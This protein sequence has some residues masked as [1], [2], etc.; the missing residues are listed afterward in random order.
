MKKKQWKIHS[1]EG[2]NEQHSTGWCE[3]ELT[4]LL[5]PA[6][7]SSTIDEAHSEEMLLVGSEKK[8][9]LAL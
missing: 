3:R 8:N 4:V 1:L 9:G 2:R 5:G 6:S 7:M